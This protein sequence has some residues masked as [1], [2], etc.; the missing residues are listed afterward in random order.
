VPEYFECDDTMPSF[1][2][3]AV[4][5][6]A[7]VKVLTQGFNTVWLFHIFSESWH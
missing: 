5:C 2:I 6:F 1:E 3:C 4:D 7:V